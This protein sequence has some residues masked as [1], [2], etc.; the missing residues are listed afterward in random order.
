MVD[1]VLVF[2]KNRTCSYCWRVVASKVGIQAGTGRTLVRGGWTL[3]ARN[4]SILG[5]PFD[6]P[7]V[8]VSSV[9]SAATRRG[10]RPVANALL[11][12]GLTR[13]PLFYILQ[14]MLVVSSC[15]S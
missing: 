1:L 8:S 7:A 13:Y 3:P 9:F 5:D 14:E 10:R 15:R 4:V 11:P 6:V 12:V 2:N